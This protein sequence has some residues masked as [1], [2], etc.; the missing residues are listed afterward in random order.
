MTLSG[1]DETGY[2][3]CVLSRTEDAKAI[4][5]AAVKTL[6]GRGG[7]KKEAFQGRISATQGEIENFFRLNENLSEF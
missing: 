6:N 4:G 3:L 7:G 1:S 2:C 5:D